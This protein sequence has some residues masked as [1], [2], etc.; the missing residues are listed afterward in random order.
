MMK[1]MNKNMILKIMLLVVAIVLCFGT[2]SF[3]DSTPQTEVSDAVS[4]LQSEDATDDVYG[5]LREIT[6]VL[7]V[8]A[9]CISGVKLAQIGF[10][11]MMGT[12]NKRSDATQSLIPWVI[13][14]FICGLWLTLGQYV[15]DL[16][17]ESGSAPTGPFDI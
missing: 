13:G 15:M 7:V 5:S 4:Q 6:N 9:M 16:L 2:V 8:V 3:A 14:V 17:T 12:A 10:K 11:F 1:I